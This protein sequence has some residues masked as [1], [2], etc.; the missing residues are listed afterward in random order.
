M[1]NTA[2]RTARSGKAPAAAKRDYG[3]LLS[4]FRPRAIETEAEN[5]RVLALVAEL[6]RRQRFSAAE[7][8]LC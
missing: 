4:Q 7:K 6:V 5:E 2:T 1:P 8:T 3:T